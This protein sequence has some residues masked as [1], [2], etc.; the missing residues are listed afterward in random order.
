[1]SIVTRGIV[2]SELL[3]RH[4]DAAQELKE[5]AIAWFDE[6]SISTPDVFTLD[7]IAGSYASTPDSI[8]N[9]IRQHITIE[10]DIAPDDW[11]PATAQVFA[12]KFLQAGGQRAWC[13]QIESAG[14]I[15]LVASEDGAAAE[16]I[17]S[18]VATGLSDGTR[19][20]IKVEIDFVTSLVT[21]YVDGSQLGA[22]VAI[23]V[24]SL[25]DSSTGIE[26]GASDLGVGAPFAG[27]IYETK[28]YK[29]IPGHTFD[30]YVLLDGVEGTYVSTPDTV[31]NSIRGSITI[32]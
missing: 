13:V 32:E 31:E 27:K 12:S 17:T 5:T 28:V 23:L 10:A 29:G 11:T 25:F 15:R 19:H 16:N 14:T 22:P 21:F 30:P 3:L 18:T 26:V 1:M 4:E 20:I 7:G 9:S 8:N 6:T 2:N 24:N